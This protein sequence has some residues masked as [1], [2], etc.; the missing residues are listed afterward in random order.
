VVRA[1]LT[2]TLVRAVLVVATVLTSGCQRTGSAGLPGIDLT[3]PAS[4]RRVEPS[5]W[6]VPGVA[7]A[8]WS[9]PE[10]S[11]L[12]VYRSLPVPG[13]SPAMLVEGLA[14][15]LENLPGLTVRQRRTETV[16]GRNAA[17][18]EVVAPGTGDAMAPSGVGTPV[19][20]QGKPL[21]PT[22]QITIGLLRRDETLYLTWH[23]P[24]SS[25]D[26]I[27]PEVQATLDSLRL[28]TPERAW[29]SYSE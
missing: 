12:V 14:N 2:I 4:W 24:E 29:S 22:Y 8:A 27:A 13:G 11:S 17:R 10:G 19:A 7:L 28:T 21:V 18:V 3:P 25:Y 23:M 20:P 5:T 1:P 15:R 16:A 26:R 6:M 9:G